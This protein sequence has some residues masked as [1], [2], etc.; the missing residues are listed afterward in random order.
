M[1]WTSGLIVFSSSQRAIILRI[2]GWD[3]SDAMLCEVAHKSIF[4]FQLLLTQ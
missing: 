1:H 4:E 2:T 3:S